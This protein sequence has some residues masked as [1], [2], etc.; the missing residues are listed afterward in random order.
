MKI[1]PT[2]PVSGIE[3]YSKI[4]KKTQVGS[5]QAMQRDEIVFSNDATLFSDA[6]KTAKQSLNDRLV[7]ANIDVAEIKGKIQDG[8]Y[9]V[10]SEQLADSIM[11]LQGYYER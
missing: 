4:N 11:M 3:Q 6:L 2:P 7:N 8:S 10:D 5:T 9:E 1:I